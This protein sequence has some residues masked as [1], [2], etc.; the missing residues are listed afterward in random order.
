MGKAMTSPLSW[1]LL[2]LAGAPVVILVIYAVLGLRA[3]RRAILADAYVEAERLVASL[4]ETMDERIDQTLAETEPIVLYEKTPQPGEPSSEALRFAIACQEGDLATLQELSAVPMD[5]R[6]ASGVPIAVLAAWEVWLLEPTAETQAQ[7]RAMALHR[8]P[9]VLSP[10]LAE[11]ADLVQWQETWERAER[12]R[13]LLRERE[14]I[15]AEALVERDRL[16][17]REELELMVMEAMPIMSVPWMELRVRLNGESLAGKA[18]EGRVLAQHSGRLQTEAVLSKEAAL[19]EPYH[20]RQRWAWPMIG[21][22]ALVSC[23]GL[24]FIHRA[25]VR[26]RHLSDAKSQFVASVSHE[27]RSPVASMRLMAEALEAGKV[28]ELGKARQFH[29]LMAGESARL[30]S[31]V[32]NVLDFARIEQDRKE[33]RFEPSDVE[34]ARRGRGDLDAPAG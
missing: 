12:G 6:L 1:R 14:S 30:A 9:S 2:L 4:G 27:L 7:L 26:E 10:M 21:G 13:A 17:L 5:Q 31:M 28:S 34:S 20:R 29:R 11:R 23:L 25:L 8:R 32:E 22:A 16:L 15:R 18:V 24:A 19:L 33:Y 3:E